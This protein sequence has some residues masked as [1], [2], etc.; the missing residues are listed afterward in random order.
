[1]SGLSAISREITTC[2]LCQS[3]KY[4]PIGEVAKG[5]E[6]DS[7]NTVKKTFK[8]P[9]YRIFG[10]R[11]CNIYF[12]SHTLTQED[13][14]NYYAELDFTMF[15]YEGLFPTD[16]I[17]LSEVFNLPIGSRVLDFGCSTGRIGQYLSDRF[18]CF[19][20][21]INEAAAAIARTRGIQILAYSELR[22]T[23]Q[24]NAILLMD[25][26]EHLVDPIALLEMLVAR[27]KRGGSLIIVTGNADAINNRDWIGEH[28]Y[29][30]APGHLLMSN[31][32]NIRWLAHRF[33][34][35]LQQIHKCSHYDLPVRERVRQHLQTLAYSCFRKEPEGFRARLLREI[36]WMNRAANWRNAPALTCV[37][38]H[39][40]AILQK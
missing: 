12:K 13:L 10:C 37:S 29:F 2:P 23:D 35:S 31:E 40:V 24:F 30:R 34:L 26:Y 7:S 22:Q 17:V 32:A 38:D 9:P 5:F 1:M 19:G 20:I 27:L 8:H 4:D 21:E 25:V 15:D 16:R 3:P 36:P 28:W 6:I 14:A 11:S 33:E 39:F 18:S